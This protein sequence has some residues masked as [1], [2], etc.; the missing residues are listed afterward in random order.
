MDILVDTGV[1]LRLLHKADPQNSPIRQTLR[2]L[3]SGGDQ[4]VATPQNIAE[5]WNVCTRPSTARGGFGL[6]PAETERK[7]R[8]LERIIRVIP[9]VPAMYELWKH[10]VIA[11]SVS[12]VQVHDARLVAAMKS[13]KI[14]HILTLNASDFG[15]YSDIHTIDPLAPTPL[16]K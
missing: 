1:L 5:F 13:H 14:T 10:L 16:P 6:S 11:R 2:R 9:D 3:K 4:F 8:L 7:L 12:G 15:R